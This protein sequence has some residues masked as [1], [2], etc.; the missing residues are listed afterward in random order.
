MV[1]K[2][3]DNDFGSVVNKHVLLPLAA[4]AQYRPE[5]NSWTNPIGSVT[6]PFHSRNVLLG[7]GDV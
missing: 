2:A 7:F 5:S 4:C 1:D 3:N 6:A